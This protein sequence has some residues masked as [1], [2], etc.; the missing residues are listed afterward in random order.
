VNAVVRTVKPEASRDFFF[1]YQGLIKG[2]DLL[3]GLSDK[4]RGNYWTL[5][6]W[7]KVNHPTIGN[8]LLE[9][10]ARLKMARMN[11]LNSFIILF[12]SFLCLIFKPEFMANSTIKRGG[13]EYLALIGSMV[14]TLLFSFEFYQRQV[15]FGDIVIKIFASLS[16]QDK[17]ARATGTV[18]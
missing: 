1:D 11:A 15:W 9:R 6:Y 2:F 10:H 12:L 14:A 8:D 16:R 7:I 4:Q 17:E 18:A 5:I 13:V 3:D